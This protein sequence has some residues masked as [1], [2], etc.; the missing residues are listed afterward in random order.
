MTKELAIAGAKE[1][2]NLS[3]QNQVVY[4][5]ESEIESETE[6]DYTHESLWQRRHFHVPITTKVIVITPDTTGLKFV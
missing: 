5:Y 2:A 6:Y 3:K 1:K 4:K